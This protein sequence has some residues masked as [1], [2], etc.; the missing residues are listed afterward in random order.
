M[1]IALDKP[2]LKQT[3]ASTLASLLLCSAPALALQE[4]DAELQ[5]IT[6]FRLYSDTFASAGQPTAQ[7]LQVVAAHGF[8]RVVYIAFTDNGKA[9]ADEDRLVKALGMEYMQIPVDWEQPLAS[10]FYNFAESVNRDPGKKTLLHCQVNA[11]ATVFSFLYRVIYEDVDVAVA[12]ADMNTVWQPNLVWRDFIFEVLAA[13]DKSAV[14]A[15][16]DWTPSE[17]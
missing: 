8:K 6:N 5:A 1:P 9:L 7:Q 11:R 16:C 14:C 4:A 17:H 10:D 15:D 13:N 3:C 12:K 2:L